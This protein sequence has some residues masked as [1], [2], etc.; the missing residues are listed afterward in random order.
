MYCILRGK[1]EFFSDFDKPQ[2]ILPLIIL[3]LTANCWNYKNI[4][5]NFFAKQQ[6]FSSLKVPKLL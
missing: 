6:K 5:G 1:T 2:S 3:F 4:L